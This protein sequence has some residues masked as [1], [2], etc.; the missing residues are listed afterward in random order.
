[1]KIDTEH[2]KP[3]DFLG[4]ARTV[5]LA[6]RELA[7]ALEAKAASETRIKALIASGIAAGNAAIKKERR[8]SIREV[9]NRR[10]KLHQA[11]L[12]FVDRLEIIRGRINK[13]NLCLD[14]LTR[15]C[16]QI[17]FK[18]D[19]YATYH[20]RENIRKRLTLEES[21]S[22][23]GKAAADDIQVFRNPKTGIEIALHDFTINGRT[24]LFEICLGSGYYQSFSGVR[25]ANYRIGTRASW[26]DDYTS[27]SFRVLQ[28]FVTKGVADPDIGDLT[29]FY[30][31]PREPGSSLPTGA[32]LLPT[33][34]HYIKALEIVAKYAKVC[35][36]LGKL[37]PI[38][39]EFEAAS[40]KLWVGE[41]E[42]G[43]YVHD[44][45]TRDD[46][47]VAISAGLGLQLV[48]LRYADNSEANKV[49]PD[50][51]E[52]KDYGAISYTK[53][54]TFYRAAK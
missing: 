53:F 34:E 4:I 21:I 36:E 33:P 11:R 51:A 38:C 7:Q 39:P 1:M 19:K 46:L 44:R 47:A 41:I 43:Q 12:E 22:W 10:V 32:R 40:R 8:V 29:H 16:D 31:Q 49:I 35:G 30:R 37:L 14:A 24:G 25:I 42:S 5:V 2:I 20:R 18:Y 54:C 28:D 23:H 9:H 52:P 50:F 27:P 48:R 3:T 17:G 45:S 26:N 6:K 15:Y 13:K